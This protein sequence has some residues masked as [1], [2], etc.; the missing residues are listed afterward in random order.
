MGFHLDHDVPDH[1]DPIFVNYC[2]LTQ[3]LT[4]SM[5]LIDLNFVSQFTFEF[6]EN[7]LY[8]EEIF[9]LSQK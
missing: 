2:Y 8:F 7:N 1:F 3:K 9:D 4:N 5:F 6:V